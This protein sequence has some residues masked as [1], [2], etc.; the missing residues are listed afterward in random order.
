MN[1]VI[2][3]T[4]STM[5]TWH[6]LTIIFSDDRQ[7]QLNPYARFILKSK[8]KIDTAYNPDRLTQKQKK[9]LAQIK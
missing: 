8:L 4:L 5:I 6:T 3:S 2:S 1:I 9:V 7:T